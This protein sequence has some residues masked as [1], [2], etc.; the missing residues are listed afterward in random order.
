MG[1]STSAQGFDRFWSDVLPLLPG[2]LLIQFGFNDANVKDFSIVQRVGLAEFEKNLRE[3]HRIAVTNNSVP[4]YVLNHTIGEVDGKQGNAK[5]YNENVVPYNAMI[6]K[7]AIDLDA[8]L[9]DLPMQMMI[10]D[11][12]VKDFVAGDQIHLSLSANHLYADMIYAGL[13]GIKL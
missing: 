1:G 10:R 9:I 3:F 13:N 8:T 7:I 5:T 12:K 11:V 2:V 6:Q 4:V